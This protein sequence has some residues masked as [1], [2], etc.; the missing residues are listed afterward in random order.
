MKQI[1]IKSF[2]NIFGN[3][4]NNHLVQ[5]VDL[6]VIEVFILFTAAVIVL[7]LVIYPTILFEYCHSIYYFFVSNFISNVI[8]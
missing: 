7:L 3:I 2:I 1:N 5:F 4:K 8:L 6:D